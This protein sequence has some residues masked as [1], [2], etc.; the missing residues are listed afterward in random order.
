MLAPMP[1]SSVFI[2][3]PSLIVPAGICAT[4]R[5]IDETLPVIDAIDLQ[6]SA[7]VLIRYAACEDR[8]QTANVR[9][10]HIP[11]VGSVY[12]TQDGVKPMK[13]SCKNMLSKVI[14]RMHWIARVDGHA[15]GPGL[16]DQPC[17]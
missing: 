14:G 2:K 9:F 5:K 1:S 4:H 15:V 13:L 16:L 17:W 11:A 3:L 12:P 6:A 10:T 8:T 7:I